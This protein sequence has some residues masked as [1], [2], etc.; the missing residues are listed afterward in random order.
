MGTSGRQEAV[1][2]AASIVAR[3]DVVY[4]DTET[5]GLD[6]TA[7]VIDIAVVDG[8][9]R[10]LLSSLVKP[11]RSIPREATR[12]HGITNAD[13]ATA[14]RWPEV[15]ATLREVLRP[16]PVVVVYNADFDRRI[17]GQ[18]CAAHRL[19]HLS[20]EW[21]CAM[22]R[23]AAYVGEWNPRYNSY[24]W[25]TLEQAASALGS[26]MPPSHRALDDAL[27]CL[28]VVRAMAGVTERR[29]II[30]PWRT[31]AETRRTTAP[32]AERAVTASIVSSS[33]TASEDRPRPAAW[34]NSIS[35]READAGVAPRWYRRWWLWLLVALALPWV[36]WIAIPLAYRSMP[37]ERRTRLWISAALAVWA[38]VW[39]LASGG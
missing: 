25:H 17:I 7:E 24:R 33:A 20:V 31:G 36:G 10:A 2:W 26:P 30:V 35:G 15:Y 18:C 28:A 14:P 1:A 12:V 34:P 6:G 21:H 9:G 39:L 11:E 22:L 13:V 16:H 3:D 4:L 19:P 32:R 37:F 23:Y 8:S 5:T 29:S 27:A 38:L